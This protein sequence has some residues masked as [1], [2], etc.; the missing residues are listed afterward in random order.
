MCLA[1]SPGDF[2]PMAAGS[3]VHGTDAL[4]VYFSAGGYPKDRYG[5]LITTQADLKAGQRVYVNVRQNDPTLACNLRYG[6][7][8]A[9]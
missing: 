2:A 4:A 1:T 9:P 3:L 5:R 8:V 6:P 7:I